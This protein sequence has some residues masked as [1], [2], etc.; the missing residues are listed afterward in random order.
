MPV[1]QHAVQD[2][3]M[4]SASSRTTSFRLLNLMKSSREVITCGRFEIVNTVEPCEE[5]VEA[6]V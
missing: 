2:L 5:K 4:A 6:T 3:K 1:R